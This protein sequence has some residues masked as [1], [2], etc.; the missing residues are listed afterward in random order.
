MAHFVEIVTFLSVRPAIVDLVVGDLSCPAQLSV[1]SEFGSWLE[2]R[3]VFAFLV[4][5]VVLIYIYI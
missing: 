2:L 3:W 5:K 1:L 4:N